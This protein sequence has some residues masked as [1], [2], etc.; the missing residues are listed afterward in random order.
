MVMTYLKKHPPAE[1]QLRDVGFVPFAFLS[2]NPQF[3]SQ[4]AGVY[5]LE[6]IRA[7]PTHL[8]R[9][10]GRSLPRGASAPVVNDEPADK[11]LRNL[12]RPQRATTD[13]VGNRVIKTIT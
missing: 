1:I 6:A 7:P 3:T 2:A 5:S 13:S 4:W 12:L 8:G 10:P 9:R 11:P